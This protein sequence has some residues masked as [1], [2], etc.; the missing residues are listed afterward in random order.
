[1]NITIIGSTQYEQIITE[2]QAYLLAIGHSVAVPAFD[3]FKGMNEL[4][5]CQHNRKLIEWADEIHVIWD[6]Q[7]T[8]TIFDMGMV[9]MARKK[10]RLVYMGLKTFPNLFRLIEK[11]TAA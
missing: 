7:S 4:E 8:G 2:H 11:E 1:M 9:F 10:V 6:Q 3:N 5:V